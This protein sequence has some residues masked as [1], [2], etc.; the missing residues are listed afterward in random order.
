MLINVCVKGS[1]DNTDA[2]L[3]CAT[4]N[5]QRR[6]SNREAT[7][8]HVH[9][10]GSPHDRWTCV[11]GEYIAIYVWY[12]DLSQAAGIYNQLQK[13]LPYRLRQIS[14]DTQLSILNERR[15]RLVLP[16]FLSR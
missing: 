16:I 9:P 13:I 14:E 7:V 2:F 12:P 5:G 4:T 11:I 10:V 6:R 8:Q 3:E 15:T 1:R